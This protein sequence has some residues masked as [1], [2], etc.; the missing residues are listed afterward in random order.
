MRNAYHQ[1]EYVTVSSPRWWAWYLV[2]GLL[3]VFSVV[4]PCGGIIGLGATTIDWSSNI[5]TPP[6]TLTHTV[7]EP[8]TQIVWI[9]Q[10]DD[11]NQILTPA[12]TVP[13]GFSAKVTGPD[14]APVATQ[15]L[16]GEKTQTASD[17]ERTGA[18]SFNAGSA[19]AYTIAV[20][21]ALPGKLGVAVTPDS[22]NEAALGLSAILLILVGLAMFVGGVTILI[23]TIIRHTRWSPS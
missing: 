2:G 23:V 8:G 21:K 3:V 22:T 6:G 20:D 10:P 5:L 14:G 18:L 17:S 9:D 11:P 7:R 19:G 1:I 13:D 16:R 12:P 4:L 15:A